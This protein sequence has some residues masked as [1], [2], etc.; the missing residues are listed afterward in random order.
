MNAQQYGKY[1]IVE[2]RDF[3]STPYWIDG[4]PVKHGYVVVRDGCNAMPGATWFQ[5]VREAKR[6]CDILDRVGEAEFWSEWRRIEDAIAAMAKG[7]E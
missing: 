2:K 5:T 1:T 6:A 3:G 4:F 7:V